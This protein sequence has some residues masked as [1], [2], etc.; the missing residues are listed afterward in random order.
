MN[1]APSF[2]IEAGKLTNDEQ[3]RFQMDDLDLAEV[4]ES[5]RKFLLNTQQVY[6]IY[7]FWL[8]F[9]NNLVPKYRLSLAYTGKRPTCRFE[10]YSERGLLLF[11]ADRQLVRMQGR[12][13]LCGVPE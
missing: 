6:F 2:W 1:R 12:G 7:S 3:F 4:L 13:V 11:F 5:D 8:T 10:D 9:N